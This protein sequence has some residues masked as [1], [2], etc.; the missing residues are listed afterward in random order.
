MESLFVCLL[1]LRSVTAEQLRAARAMVQWSQDELARRA[2][3]QRRAILRFEN[4]SS[5]PLDSTLRALE[6]VL[7]EAGVEFC[8]R[9][10]GALGVF[11]R[12]A[13]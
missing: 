3:L 8:R 12:R 5:I 2:G 7:S 4:G 10:D 1:G 13:G 6:R 9:A 11:F